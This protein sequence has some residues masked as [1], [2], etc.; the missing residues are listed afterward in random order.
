MRILHMAL[1]EN[2]LYV[3]SFLLT[4][5]IALGLREVYRAWLFLY[6]Y[7]YAVLTSRIKNS[8]KQCPVSFTKH[9]IVFVCAVES[10]DG[11]L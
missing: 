6:L 5:L 10:E 1:I 8:T 2:Y 4:G 3:L 11:Q 9:C 7:L